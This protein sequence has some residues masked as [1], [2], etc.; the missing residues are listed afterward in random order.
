MLQ[1]MNILQKGSSIHICLSSKQDMNIIETCEDVTK[2][3]FNT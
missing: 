2:P 3:I 1:H